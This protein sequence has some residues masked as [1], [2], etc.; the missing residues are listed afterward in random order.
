MK[1]AISREGAEELRKLGNILQIEVAKIEDATDRLR[2]VVM[3]LAA[4]FGEFEENLGDCI[5]GMQALQ[6]Q[7][8][9]QIEGL[10][11]LIECKAD[12]IDEFVNSIKNS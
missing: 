12:A 10:V 1:F 6:V 11:P 9:E 3:G 2:D 8:A 4:D 7:I 5:S